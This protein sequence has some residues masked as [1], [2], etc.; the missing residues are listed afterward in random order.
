MRVSIRMPW[1][2]A[3]PLSSVADV[4]WTVDGAEV[5]RDSITWTVDGVTRRL[6]ELPPLHD[7][8][9]YVLDSAILEGDR[10]SSADQTPT[11]GEGSEHDIGIVLAL[12]IPYITTDFG[13]L[14]IEESDRKRMRKKVLA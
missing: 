4:Q 6:D 10:P 2:R 11:A 8:W 3:L 9:W 1:Y 14:K 5:P 12:F 7:E 13:V